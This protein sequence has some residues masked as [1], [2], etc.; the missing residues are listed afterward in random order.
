M[1]RADRELAFSGLALVLLAAGRSERFGSPKLVAP[2]A[3]Q[4][5]ASH[6]AQM[7]AALPFAHR[8]AVIG[9]AA[10]DLAVLG[11]ACLPLDP[12]GAAQARSVAIGVGAARAAGASAV[13]IALADMPLIPPAHI[14]AL[15]AA[16]DGDRIATTAGGVIMPPV[17]FGAAHFTTLTVLAGDR[18][19]A[20]LLSGAPLLA[21]D[22]ACALD[23]DRPQD[24]AR[25]EAH[26]SHT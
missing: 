9:P 25:A 19:G 4:P 3:G 7:L 23:I 16:F 17:I 1:S 13:L 15:A 10:P 8:F 21:L 26:L 22:P 5:L 11:Y 24:L 20:A 6:A 18:G 12:P 14:H 2:L